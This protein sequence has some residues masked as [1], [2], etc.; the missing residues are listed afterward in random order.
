MNTLLNNSIVLITGAS[1]GIGAACAQQF[2]QA[3]SK[4]ILLAR[5]LDKLKELKEL[6][7]HEFPQCSVY[8]QQCDVRNQQEVASVIQALPEELQAIDI[9]VNNAGLSRGLE[10]IHEGV[11]QNW[12]EMIDTNVKGLLYVTRAVSPGMVTR[13]KGMI[14]NIAS[15]AGRETYPAGNVYCATKSAARTISEA[16]RIDLNGTGIRVVNID[17]GMV[18]TEFS[19]VRFRGD[20]SRADQVYKGFQPLS[21]DD[22]ADAVMYCASRPPHV[23]IADI[24][25]LPTAQANTT[26]VYKEL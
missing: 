13:K 3:G 15:I 26:T 22:V 21:G 16:T 7:E 24:L 14:I 8:V 23:T 12:E 1:S 20:K 17:P 5:R 18:E 6:L 19:I 9:L 10:K 4:L 25:I 2:A 11:L